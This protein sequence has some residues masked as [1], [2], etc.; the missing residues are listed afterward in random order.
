MRISQLKK[1]L[2][3]VVTG[4]KC[5]VAIPV[6]GPVLRD[7]VLQAHLDPAVRQIDYL[8]HARLSGQ[9][10]ALNAILLIR[11]DARYILSIAEVGRAR[12]L[13]DG[14]VRLITFEEQG[15]RLLEL[16]PE[17][18]RQ[19]PRLSNVREVWKHSRTHVHLK[20]RL[21]IMAVLADEGSLSLGELERRVSHTMDFATSVC[22]L[23]CADI[24]EL[25]LTQR[26]LGPRTVVRE[27]R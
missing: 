2:T 6:P 7:A 1:R 14:E 19:E 11:D 10:V 26:P 8:P 27:R 9:Q 20:D 4:A 5:A 17:E 13:D 15:L 25:E 18:I 21:Q 24:V 12:D 23:A 16:T 22:A 3:P